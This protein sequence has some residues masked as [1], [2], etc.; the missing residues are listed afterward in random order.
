[1]QQKTFFFSFF[2]SEAIT[3]DLRKK[4]QNLSK[5]KMMIMMVVVDFRKRKE[6]LP[7]LIFSAEKKEKKVVFFVVSA[8]WS[9]GRSFQFF[10]WEI[11]WPLQRGGR[12]GTTARRAQK[13]WSC[14][15]ACT[16]VHPTKTDIIGNPTNIASVNLVI[17]CNEAF[18][19]PTIL[20][21][22]LAF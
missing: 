9:D 3:S 12:N 11:C 20:T 16:T 15:C 5:K 4:H 18:F 6:K 10:F 2:L 19:P 1:M 17:S 21:P 8:V 14:W 13:Q 22:A 7:Q